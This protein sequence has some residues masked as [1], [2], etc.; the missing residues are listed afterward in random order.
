MVGNLKKLKRYFRQFIAINLFVFTLLIYS[1]FPYRFD[2]SSELNTNLEYI[3]IYLSIHICRCLGACK[4][5]VLQLNS[6]KYT[7]GSD[8]PIYGRVNPSGKG[9]E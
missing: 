1:M 8:L 9:I 4:S 6:I 7:S 5:V 3:S 2:L